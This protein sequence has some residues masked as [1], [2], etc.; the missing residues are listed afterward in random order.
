MNKLLI[1]LLISLPAFSNP[2]E[3]CKNVE[4]FARLIMTERQNGTPASELLTNAQTDLIKDI[5]LEA[6]SKPRM[7]A[8]ETKQRLVD[9]YANKVYLQCYKVLSSELGG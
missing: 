7:H 2:V 4:K 9:D 6:Y 8:K 3:D 5:I 1:L